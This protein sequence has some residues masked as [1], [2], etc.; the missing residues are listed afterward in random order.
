MD[1]IELFKNHMAVDGI[2]TEEEIIADGELHRFKIT[3]DKQHSQ[4]G[5]YVLYADKLPSGAYGNW[6]T[7][8]SR[9]WCLK[10]QDRMT[11]HEWLEHHR[12]MEEARLKRDQEKI[13]EQQHA[14]QRASTIWNYC[15]I[16]N[17]NH[18]YLIK[19]RIPPFIARQ[20]NNVLV[21]P[22]IDLQSKIWSLQFIHADGSKILLSGG[23][24]KSN[25][26]PINGTL[27]DSPILICE[28]FATGGTLA[29]DYPHACVISA[30]DANNLEFVASK[31]RR[32]NPNSK[33][34]ICADDDRLTQGNPGQTKARQ[35]AIASG[36]L[37]SSPQW[38]SNAP[39]SLTDFNDLAC[40][41]RDSKET[42]A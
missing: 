31:I 5:W 9:K 17:P 22:I 11:K 12:K 36:S 7:S 21:L 42:M 10:S 34:I 2:V 23:A 40:W 39:V 1:F 14:A 37:L 24:K 18:P 35:A 30:I 41:S 16:A 32:N 38:P 27:D 26:I 25:F 20:R 4:N 13:Q 28:G 33:I 19:K 6:K 15:E 3:G 8:I 29:T